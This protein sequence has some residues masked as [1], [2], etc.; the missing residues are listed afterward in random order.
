MQDFLKR[1]PVQWEDVRFID[2]YPGKYVVLARKSGNSWYI[3]GI[4]A[5]N[6]E[7][8]I[9]IDLSSFHKQNGLY[10]SDGTTPLSFITE[11]F[12]LN[13]SDLRQIKIKPSGGFVLVLK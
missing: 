6:T 12:Q 3:A 5:E 13:K 10:I 2:G 11:E 1:L 4:N 7:K 9:S 8:T